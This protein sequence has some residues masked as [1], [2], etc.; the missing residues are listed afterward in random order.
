MNKT[1]LLFSFVAACLVSIGEPVNSMLGS[2]GIEI[3]YDNNS[4]LP[5]GVVAVEYL[6][7]RDYGRF[8]SPIPLTENILSYG[9]TM[10]LR[11]AL[12]RAGNNRGLLSHGTTMLAS[13]WVIAIGSSE[14]ECKLYSYTKFQKNFS[15]VQTET[16]L[17]IYVDKDSVYL[18]VHGTMQ[19]GRYATNIPYGEN[20]VILGYD[21][22]S[23]S[24]VAG[25]RLYA[26]QMKIGDELVVD[27]IPVRIGSEG[28]MFDLISEEVIYNAGSL[29]FIVGPDVED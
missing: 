17:V 8:L 26:F 21:Q 15:E 2:D 18:S 3:I 16:D 6:E 19:G 12:P 23:S 14:G 29:P 24:A 27:M 22:L 10:N 5:D 25:T 9:V 7:S 13:P 11:V 4:P 28:A 1:I 20:L